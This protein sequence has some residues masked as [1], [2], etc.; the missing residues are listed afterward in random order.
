VQDLIRHALLPQVQ[1]K[2]PDEIEALRVLDPSCGSGHF[3]V[4]ALRVLGRQ[5]HQAYW[6]QF[7]GQC[8]PTFRDAAKWK[9]GDPEAS[10]LEARK[11]G[12]E[13]RAWCKR[14]IAERCLFGVDLNPMA[15]QLAQVALWIE[16]LAGDRPLTFFQ[17]HIRNGNSLLGSQLETLEQPPLSVMSLAKSEDLFSN[18]QGLFMRKVREQVAEAARLRLVI[19]APGGEENIKELEFK[20]AQCKKA[21]ETLSSARL[22]FNLRSASAFVVGERNG[23][24]IRPIW[25]QWETFCSLVEKPGALEAYAQ[26]QVWW[27]EFCAVR[28]R[29][30]FFHWELEYPELFLDKQNGGFD[31]ILGNPPWEKVKPDKKEYYAKDDVLIRAFVGGELDARIRELQANKPGLKEGF[32]SYENRLKTLS[33]CMKQGGDF[34]YQDW[35]ING[36]STGGD[37]DLFR[38]FVERCHQVLKPEGRAGLVLPS[39]V[40]NNE[41]A[42]GLRHMLVCESRIERFYAFENKRK[43]FPIHSS[44]KFISICFAKATPKPEGFTAAF[45]RHDLDELTLPPSETKAWTVWM[46]KKELEHLSPGTLAFLEFREAKDQEIIKRMYE[47]RPLLGATG[48]GTWN[49]KFYS[50]Y[51]MTFDKDLW[52]Q[53]SGKLYSVKQVLGKEPDD[54]EDTRARMAKKGFWPLY[55]GKQ[56]DQFMI[57]TKPVERWVNLETAENTK[58]KPEPG[59]KLVF[60]DIARNTDERTCIAAVLPEGSCFGHTL[61]GFIVDGNLDAVATVMNSYIF[62]YAMRFRTAGTHL[63]FTYLS[64]MPLPDR[65]PAKKLKTHSANGEAVHVMDDKK[66]WDA[67]V[68]SNLEVLK[69]YGLQRDDL[70]YVLNAFPVQTRKRSAFMEFLRG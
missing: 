44:F 49:A 19:D 61:S 58:R 38:F 66:H 22:L 6:K 16:S 15:V 45:M 50:E 42:T 59:P 9:S 25:E 70:I 55:E 35:E 62:D 41:G 34:K 67:L 54:F 47:G 30:R 36:K 20:Q 56:I 43:I 64:R 7:K 52:T 2:T 48:E 33:A 31:A 39:A 40:Y 68:E 1:G 65:L 57:D 37:I 3:L 4:E 26:S 11:T 53:P 63:S 69:A 17:H 60:R 27:D 51:H 28:D 21:E 8:P 46:K 10:D 24:T 18:M 13:A 29:E 14:R 12:D 5:L 32:E 23:K